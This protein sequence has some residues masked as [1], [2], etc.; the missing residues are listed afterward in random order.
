MYRQCTVFLFF[1]KIIELYIDTV[2]YKWY[3]SI[4]LLKGD[5]MVKRNMMQE[6]IFLLNT[7]FTDILFN[8]IFVANKKRNHFDR[9]FFCRGSNKL[10]YLIAL[11]PNFI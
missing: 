10:Q 3:F 4:K 6:F 5:D 9:H 2:I 11:N 1:Q 7:S 8:V